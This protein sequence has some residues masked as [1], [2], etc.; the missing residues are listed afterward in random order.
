MIFRDR[1]GGSPGTLAENAAKK[2]IQKQFRPGSM[3][4]VSWVRLV[5]PRLAWWEDSP[6]SAILPKIDTAPGDMNA[7]QTGVMPILGA[8]GVFYRKEGLISPVS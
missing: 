2:K 5:V 1:V 7:P 3:T 8:S 4:G 6:E